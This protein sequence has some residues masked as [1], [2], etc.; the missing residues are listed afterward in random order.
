[1]NSFYRGIQ[2]NWSPDSYLFYNIFFLG[3]LMW[4]IHQNNNGDG[5]KMV[6]LS[7]L[8]FL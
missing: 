8:I 6:S 5:M 7:L 1:M 2:G 3:T 4:A